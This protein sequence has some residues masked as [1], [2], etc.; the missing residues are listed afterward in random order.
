LISLSATAFFG[1]QSPFRGPGP[2]GPAP[3]RPARP[4]PRRQ[5]RSLDDKGL[6]P[7]CDSPLPCSVL[8]VL[9]T[10][11][12]SLPG[13]I[14][15]QEWRLRHPKDASAASALDGD[16]CAATGLPGARRTAQPPWQARS[17]WRDGGTAWRRVRGNG[18]AAVARA[19]RPQR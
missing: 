17:P 11:A 16:L 18:A 3:S 9:P 13:K 5:R 12:G 4:S 14:I 7:L 10:G 2:E 1:A 8:S 6:V 15:S 19:V